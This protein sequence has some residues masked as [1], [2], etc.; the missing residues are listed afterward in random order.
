LRRVKGNTFRRLRDDGELGEEI[1]FE[2]GP[3]GKVAGFVWNS[4]KSKKL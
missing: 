4:Q 1:V 2:T 3:D